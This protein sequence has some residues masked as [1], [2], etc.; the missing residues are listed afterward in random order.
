MPVVAPRGDAAGARRDVGAAVGG[1]ASV[2]HDEPRIVDPAVGIFEG[3]T[4][5]GL[6]RL[7]GFVPPEVEA[8]RRRQDV[9]AA[10]VIV[11]KEAE[12]DDRPRPQAAVMRED[13]AQRP[14]DMRARRR[15][16]L[17]ARAAPREPAG[18]RRYSR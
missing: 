5:L 13:K 9:A 2:E 15:A 7:P 16:G 1:V 3:A 4:V 17:R 8:P 14:D 12:P 6:E 18:T 10:E 11:E